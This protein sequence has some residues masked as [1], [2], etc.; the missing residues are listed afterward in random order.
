[1]PGGSALRQ[2]AGPTH[3]HE[4]KAGQ[5]GHAVL[6]H[7]PLWPLLRRHPCRL[8]RS[9]STPGRGV[10]RAAE[11]SRLLQPQAPG[12]ADVTF[13][14][15]AAG[16]S[17]LHAAPPPLSS[18]L[19]QPG[20]CPR[21]KVLFLPVLAPAACF[22]PRRGVQQPPPSCCCNGFPSRCP[23][24]AL[25][26]PCEAWWLSEL[27]VKNRKRGSIPCILQ[28]TVWGTAQAP[29]PPLGSLLGQSRNASV[30]IAG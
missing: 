1:M 16:A 15:G 25:H 9:A 12:A 6:D 30:R 8:P 2:G 11:A 26:R 24:S 17:A 18:P 3:L 5:E 20:G 4:I 28:Q 7:F 21:G 10:H 19:Q 14:A 13:P 29:T 27:D 22:S 23:P